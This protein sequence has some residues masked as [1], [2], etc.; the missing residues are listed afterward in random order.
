MP[1]GLS[2]AFSTFICAMNQL[3]RPFIG[4]FVVAYFD[5][6]IIYSANAGEHLKHVKKVFN[7]LQRKKFYVAMKKCVFM[8]FQVL[9]L[10]YVVFSTGLEVDATKVQ[11]VKEW[12]RPTNLTED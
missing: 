12:L 6:T 11:A 3:L 10:G 5:D 8:A 7:V 9:F 4:Q 2:N 1:F